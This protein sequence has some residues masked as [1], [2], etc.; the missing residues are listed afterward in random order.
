MGLVAFVIVVVGVVVI[1][2]FVVIVVVVVVAVG[3][4]V[5]SMI[6]VV[7]AVAAAAAG[8]HVCCP[9]AAVFAHGCYCWEKE[10]V[11]WQL[12]LPL[13]LVSIAAMVVMYAGMVA[14]VGAVGWVFGNHG[15]FS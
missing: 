3:F 6:V 8:L 2:V 4:V 5:V 14:F 7:V 15:A 10:G 11:M 12:L 9:V 1:A 13:L